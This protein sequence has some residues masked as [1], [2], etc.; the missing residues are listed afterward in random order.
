MNCKGCGTAETDEYLVTVS[1]SDV[2]VSY[3]CE[4]CKQAVEAH[5]E[6]ERVEHPT[7][8]CPNCGG[9]RTRPMDEW[10]AVCFNCDEEWWL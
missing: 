4:D 5:K 1:P 6:V 8:D 7:P 10:T 9:R 3:L 2:M